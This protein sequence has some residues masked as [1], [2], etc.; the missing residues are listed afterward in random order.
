MSI[1]LK[2]NDNY[3]E[4]Y[5]DTY[6]NKMNYLV[7]AITEYKTGSNYFNVFNFETGLGKSFTV[8]RVLS[9]LIN[10]LWNNEQK[11]LIVKKFNDESIKSVNFI[12]EE[13]LFVKDSALAIT[14]E[15]WS[16]YR[17]KLDYI[18]RTKF[19]YISHQRY[20]ALCENEELRKEIIKGRD[21]LIIDEKILFPVYTYN[22]KRYI[23]ILELVPH[24]LRDSL[25]KVCKPLND[26]IALHQTL[27]HTN[28]VFKPKFKIHPAT[29][30]NFINDIKVALENRTISQTENRN[31][32]IDFINELQLFYSNSQCAYNSGN[33][34]THNPKHN[35]W[36][37][38]NNIILDASAMID[39]TYFCNPEK[40]K[41]LNQTRII[42][43]KGCSFNVIK[44]NSAKSKVMKYS[45][46]Y[47]TE[48][49]Q[50]IKDNQKET[51]K[52][53]IVGHKDFAGKI[54]NE[55]IQL[56][57]EEDI[58]ID[59]SDKE[60]DAD[61]NDQSVAISWYGNLVGKNWAGDF[62]QVWLIST[63]NIPL[64]Q[65]LIHF[66]HYSDDK[67]GNKST[68]VI[69]GKYKNRYF[70]AI[71]KGYVAAEMYQ[72]L[73]RIQRSAKPKGD[74]YIVS[75][76]EELVSDILSQIKNAEIKNEI[77][78]DFVKAEQE[79]KEQEKQI[80]KKPDQVDMF[81]EYILSEKKGIYKKSDIANQL[82]ISKINRVLLD[83]R[84]KILINKRLEIHTRNIQIL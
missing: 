79:E 47:F 30:N 71:Q 70:K 15:N 66:L 65:Y 42:D 5:G 59:K 8:D 64:E 77:E 80:N 68:E 26:F 33:I 45:K 55:L 35:H 27:K 2:Y 74:F 31:S 58:W 11:F 60:N 39:G 16:E 28:K 29:L 67:L 81:I 48:M 73:K 63:P 82:K 23:K 32:V 6:I 50:R 3:S 83:T 43:H 19:V 4:V 84:V 1:Q 76:D 13:S 21:T 78:L 36:G 52:V 12:Q 22:D 14:H 72:S 56:Y 17:F 18:H 57:K 25:T 46:K 53:L 41:I 61:Y 37:L 49:A 9:K 51:D 24:G 40:F 44:F 54:H 10:E 69:K 38:D 7:K 75:N 34:S 20:I 62:T